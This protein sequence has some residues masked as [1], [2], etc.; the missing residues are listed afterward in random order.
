VSETAA[1]FNVS[2]R[3]VRR[4]IASGAI[5]A[6]SIGR[7]VRIRPRDIGRLIAAGGIYND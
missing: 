5:P 4:L 3:T 2:G 7:A 6:I 1:I